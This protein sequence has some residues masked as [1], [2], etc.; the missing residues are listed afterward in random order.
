MK[1]MRETALATAEERQALIAS[2][3]TRLNDVLHMRV[4]ETPDLPVIY[5]G[6]ISLAMPTSEEVSRQQRPSCG[7]PV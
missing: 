6:R 4:R 7:M 5:A 2:L 3:P 1:V